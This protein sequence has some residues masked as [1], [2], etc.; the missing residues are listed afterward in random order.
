VGAIPRRG[1]VVVEAY[2]HGVEAS[3]RRI[4]EARSPVEEEGRRWPLGRWGQRLGWAGLATGEVTVEER[5]RGAAVYEARCRG[6]EGR[7]P[8]GVSAGSARRSTRRKEMVGG[9][10]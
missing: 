4:W 5:R 8:K 10:K 9:G 7:R 2:R 3:R 6:M 1:A